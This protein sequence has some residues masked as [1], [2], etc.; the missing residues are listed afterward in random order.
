MTNDNDLIRRG[1]AIEACSGFDPEGEIRNLPSADM[2]DATKA[3][4]AK[5]V[6]ALR[7]IA[8]QPDYRLPKPQTIALAVLAEI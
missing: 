1:D 6:E 8:G 7:E 2:H 4:L 5:A 3:Q